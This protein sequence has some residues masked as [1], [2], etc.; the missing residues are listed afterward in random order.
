MEKTRRSNK[1]R[2]RLFSRC[3]NLAIEMTGRPLWAATRTGPAW[4]CFAVLPSI[5]N[6]QDTDTEDITDEAWDEV[7]PQIRE[8]ITEYRR[9][10]LQLLVDILDGM[11][12][13]EVL[14]KKEHPWPRDLSPTEAQWSLAA[15]ATLQERL[16]SPSSVFRCSGC[17]GEYRYPDVIGH[18]ASNLDHGNEGKTSILRAR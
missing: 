5:S 10:V 16:E 7:A 1:R 12:V 17:H 11:A 9:Q 4:H 15:A 6:L 18:V 8:W 3:D 2:E 14:L 13:D